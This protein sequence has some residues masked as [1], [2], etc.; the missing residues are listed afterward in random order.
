MIEL[1]TCC[2]RLVLARDID[3]TFENARAFGS[4]VV[5]LGKRVDLLSASNDMLGCAL[6]E[7]S[8]AKGKDAKFGSFVNCDLPSSQAK[9]AVYADY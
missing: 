6:K 9:V 8:A 1:V 2:C 3:Q 5:E 4:L 7:L